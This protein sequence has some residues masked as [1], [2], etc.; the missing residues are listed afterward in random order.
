MRIWEKLYQKFR[1]RHFFVNN[2]VLWASVPKNSSR[3]WKNDI[4]T[5]MVDIDNLPPIYWG[6][7]II[8]DPHQRLVSGLSE[9]KQRKKRPESLEQMLDQFEALIPETDEHLIPQHYFQEEY[10]FKLINFEN[11]LTVL[12]KLA[13]HEI[14][15]PKK[16]RLK[17]IPERPRDLYSHPR[18]KPLVEKYYPTDLELW[19]KVLSYG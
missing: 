4:F 15:A 6:F 11:Q 5:Q 2:H 17:R 19:N 10:P 18:V 12:P 16:R 8:R 7:I 13:M 3:V 1:P 9:W 14:R